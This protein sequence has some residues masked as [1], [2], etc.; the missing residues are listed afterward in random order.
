MLKVVTTAILLILPSLLTATTLYVD[1]TLRVGV[2]SEPGR[3]VAPD[4]V[5]K[6]GAK[7]ELLEKTDGYYRVRTDTGV[8]GWVR[9]SYMNEQ[10]PARFLLAD[11]KEQNNHLQNE[12]SQLK[13]QIDAAETAVNGVR[14][15]RSENEQMKRVIA[16]QREDNTWLIWFSGILAIGPLGFLFGLLWYRYQIMKKLGGLTL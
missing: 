6:T 16:L 2:R 4:A 14:Q 12:I 15:L 8:E 5:I 11:M 7:V 1:D 13:Q 10:K 3:T 9:A